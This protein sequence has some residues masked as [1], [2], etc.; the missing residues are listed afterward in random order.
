MVAAVRDG[1]HVAVADRGLGIPAELL[2][3]LFRKFS[4]ASG[5]ATATGVDRSSLGLAICKGIVEA[6]GGRIWPLT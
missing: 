2:P 4:R 5:E 3:E 6:Q 1:V